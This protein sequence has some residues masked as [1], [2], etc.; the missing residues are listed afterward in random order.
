MKLDVL[1]YEEKSDSSKEAWKVDKFKAKAEQQAEELRRE[2]GKELRAYSTA[3][4]LSQ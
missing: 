1:E 3:V 4:R 2:R